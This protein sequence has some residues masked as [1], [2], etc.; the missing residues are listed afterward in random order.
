[1]R[2]KKLLNGFLHQLFYIVGKGISK[3]ASYLLLFPVSAGAFEFYPEYESL[4]EAEYSE[5]EGPDFLGSE[6]FSDEITF[7]KPFEWDYLAGTKEV[8]ADTSYGSTGPKHFLNEERLRLKKWLLPNE[9]QFRFTRTLE[10]TREKNSV[11]NMMELLYKFS[12]SYG[13]A[14]YGD[15]SHFKRENDVGVA[16]LFWPEPNHEI[17]L[18]HTWTDITRQGRNDRDD[19]FVEPSLP[20]TYGISGKKFESKNKFLTYFLRHDSFTKWQFPSSNLL[21]QYLRSSAGFSFADVFAEDYRY[22][23][24]LEADKKFESKNSENWQTERVLL[25][26]RVDWS[27]Y[28][29]GISAATRK[30][31][32]IPK[33]ES[34]HADLLPQFGWLHRFK[35]GEYS[36]ISHELSY[37]FDWHQESLAPAMTSFTPRTGV[38][39]HRLTSIWQ[40][41]FDSDT[42]LRIVLSF[43]LDNF[44]GGE[45]WEGG[46]GQFKLSF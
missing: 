15:P 6:Y 30:W 32:S 20:Y 45:S 14:L 10:R 26:S 4:T 36:Q 19:T 9:L 27:E 38:L 23:V 29:F 17:R 41:D 33:G 16:L 28:F 43:D 21:Y 25:H 44:G 39:E 12:E 11:H 2:F 34:R 40:F 24:K 7:L 5:F 46:A 8:Y 22:F 3:F 18:F 35:K 1:M 42:T 31:V 13:V 37:D